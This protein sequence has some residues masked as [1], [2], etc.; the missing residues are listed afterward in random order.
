MQYHLSKQIHA[1]IKHGLKP[2][3]IALLCHITEADDSIEHTPLSIVQIKTKIAYASFYRALKRLQDLNVISIEPAPNDT[4]IKHLR[5]NHDRLVEL[6]G[7]E[8]E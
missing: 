6:L 7:G 2:N 8:N 3:E 1:L 4:R 5:R